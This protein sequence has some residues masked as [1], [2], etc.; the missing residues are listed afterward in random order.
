M[1]FHLN[2]HANLSSLRATLPNPLAPWQLSPSLDESVQGTAPEEGLSFKKC[3]VLPHHS[4]WK[5]V[6]DRFHIEPPE[7]E[8]IE[9]IYCIRQE[10][11]LQAFL[12][13]MKGFEAKAKTISR[14][15]LITPEQIKV[16]K[17]W[18]EM[19]STWLSPGHVSL[20]LASVLERMA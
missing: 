16:V 20:L 7:N 18:E 3:L 1:S 11:H 19:A 14:T 12:I 13:G 8:E 17:T 9:A 2:A 10:E 15:P 5:F 4:E 6:W